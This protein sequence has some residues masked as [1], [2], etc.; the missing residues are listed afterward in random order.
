MYLKHTDTNIIAYVFATKF[1]CLEIDKKIKQKKK[2]FYKL[3]CLCIRVL[4]YISVYKKKIKTMSLNGVNKL[5]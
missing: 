3:V 1:I 5:Y 2:Q 4:Y